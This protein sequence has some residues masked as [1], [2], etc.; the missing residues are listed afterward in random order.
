[1]DPSL[2]IRRISLSANLLKP[3]EDAVE[4]L[5]LFDSIDEK[6][7]EE[8]LNQTLIEIQNRYG[9]N[10]VIKGT[11]LEQGATTLERNRQIGGHKA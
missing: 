6:N 9:K 4:Q 1:M 7:K 11:D 3:K 10:S 5:S 2:S 8:K